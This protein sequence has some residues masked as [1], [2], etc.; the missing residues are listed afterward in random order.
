MQTFQMNFEII[1]PCIDESH[2]PD[3]SPADYVARL[4]V[5]KSRMGLTM[6]PRTAANIPVLGADTCVV[7]DSL[8]LGKPES[9]EDAFRMLELLAGRRHE[10]YTAVAVTDRRATH[11]VTVESHV[12]FLELTAT[13]IETYLDSAEY[14]GRAGSYAIQGCA[15]NFISRL[16][17][18][19][20]SVVG[21]PVRETFELFCSA[22]VSLIDYDDVVRAMNLEFPALRQCKGN[23]YV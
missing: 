18:S 14:D 23:H 17:G 19:W 6:A 7:A 3:E 11:S 2:K 1:H 4:A 13:E 15:S 10:V 22:G 21:L 8:I 9:R 16:D 12:E 20:S 5:E